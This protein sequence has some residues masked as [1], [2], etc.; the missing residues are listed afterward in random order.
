MI[1]FTLQ[2]HEY[3]TEVLIKVVNGKIMMKLF[4]L[5]ADNEFDYPWE[6]LD[7]EV[8]DCYGIKLGEV[9]KRIEEEFYAEQE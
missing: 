9:F 7:I 6:N 3:G 1:I 4:N 5:T 2:T 8:L